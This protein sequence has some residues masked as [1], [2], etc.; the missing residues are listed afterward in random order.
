MTKESSAESLPYLIE[1]TRVY[2]VISA[3]KPD[4]IK[5]IIDAQPSVPGYGPQVDAMHTPPARYKR[6]EYS[7]WVAPEPSGRVKASPVRP[8]DLRRPTLGD[9]NYPVG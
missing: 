8:V 3:Y 9:I 1:K 5:H 4:I 7:P 6:I 2:S